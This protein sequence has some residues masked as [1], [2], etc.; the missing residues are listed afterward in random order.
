MSKE[1]IR[2]EIE[3]NDKK[4]MIKRLSGY[5]YQLKQAAEKKRGK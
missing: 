4:E 5:A 2:V 3:S 1:N